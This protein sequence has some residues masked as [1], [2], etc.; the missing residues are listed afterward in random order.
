MKN[1]YA[2]H[3]DGIRGAAFLMI[4]VS[5]LCHINFLTYFGRISV[6]LFLFV[7][8]F[9]ITRLLIK[10]EGKHGSVNIQ[11]FYIRRMLRLYP[12]LLFMLLVVCLVLWFNNLSIHWP[13]I[14]SGIFYYTNYE[15]I[16]AGFPKD[17]PKFFDALWSLSVQE[18]FYLAFPVIFAFLYKKP[19]FLG[20]LFSLILI[21]LVFRFYNLVGL[22]PSEYFLASYFPTHAR[23]DTILIGALSAI[24]VFQKKSR[25]YISWLTNRWPLIIG[26]TIMIGTYL[27]TNLY[28]Q[29]TI[30]F[31]LYGL[32]LFLIVPSL[33]FYY[34]ESVFMKALQNPTM[35]IIG[36][37]SYSLYLFHWVAINTSKMY[38]KTN[39]LEYYSW[40]IVGTASL[41]L[42][43]YHFIEKPV[44]NL[45]RKYGSEVAPLKTAKA[46]N[47]SFPSTQLETIAVLEQE[48]YL[49]PNKK[50]V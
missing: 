1:T 2:P 7:S 13:G 28:F 21:V 9:L 49:I 35:L 38:F 39:T 23:V 11:S 10:E 30:A 32:A 33:E 42:I 46:L 27:N 37:L 41:A 44:I 8:G 50:K 12:G 43:S 15:L 14:F 24:L 29:A 47:H 36:K 48:S 20:I 19:Y 45:R 26:L 6:L 25:W 40:S 22:A 17:Y 4:F 34:K 3:L 16:Y 5:H 18:H 31:S